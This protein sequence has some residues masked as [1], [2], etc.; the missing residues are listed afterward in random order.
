M[1]AVKKILLNKVLFVITISSAFSGSTIT[2]H[3]AP[4]ATPSAVAA[5]LS[6]A[7]NT[8]EN[9]QNDV[10]QAFVQIAAKA[11]GRVGFAARVL[12]TGEETGMNNGEHYPM[13]SV[14]KLPISMAVLQRVDRGELKLDQLVRVEPMLAA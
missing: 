5:T 11:H 8:A 2:Q 3:N 10:D 12:E 7:V 4:A 6:P 14:Y 13:H 9:S 1:P